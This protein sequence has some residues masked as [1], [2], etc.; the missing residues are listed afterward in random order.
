[1]LLCCRYED[2]FRGP[3]RIKAA[4]LDVD[5]GGA[6]GTEAKLASLGV[7]GGGVQGSQAKVAVLGPSWGLGVDAAQ[8]QGSKGK[9]ASSMGWGVVGCMKALG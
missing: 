8:V 6:Q 4:S 5:G 1:M 9:T 3:R 2:R 7:D